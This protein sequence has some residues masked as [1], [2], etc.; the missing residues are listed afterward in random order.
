LRGDTHAVALGQGVAGSARDADWFTENGDDGED[1]EA[2]GKA[3]PVGRTSVT[4][5]AFCVDE[6]GETSYGSEATCDAVVLGQRAACWWWTPA[7]GAHRQRG[8][9]LAW[10]A[11]A[12]VSTMPTDSSRW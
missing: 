8:A 4:L 10:D 3:V 1:C 12:S 5:V 2:S 9:C 6:E 7:V 11:R